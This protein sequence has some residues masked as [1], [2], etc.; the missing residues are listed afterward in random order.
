MDERFSGLFKSSSTARLVNIF[1]KP[2]SDLPSKSSKPPPLLPLS[3]LK[4]SV[5]LAKILAPLPL[6]R[7]PR[8]VFVIRP[9][10]GTCAVMVRF[11]ITSV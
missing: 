11:L 9:P 2:L 6:W 3:E 8:R 4:L 7:M 5:R 1:A 10:R